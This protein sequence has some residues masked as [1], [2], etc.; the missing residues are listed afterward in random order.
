MWLISD[1]PAVSTSSGSDL[2]EADDEES[3]IGVGVPIVEAKPDLKSKRRFKRLRKKTSSTASTGSAETPPL[4][5]GQ[6]LQLLFAKSALAMNPCMVCLI[7][8]GF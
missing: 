3:L 7:L 8:R 6:L 2:T 1:V 5:Q 4:D